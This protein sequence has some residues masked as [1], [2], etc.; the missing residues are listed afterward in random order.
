[1]V[2][3]TPSNTNTERRE[4]LAKLIELRKQVHNQIQ[5][6]E[7]EVKRREALRRKPGR[8]QALKRPKS[9]PPK[10]RIPAQW[11]NKLEPF[12]FFNEC[13][14]MT[15]STFSQNFPHQF[16]SQ[17][18]NVL[19]N[20]AFV[21]L[22]A[23][24]ERGDG[25]GDS[26]G[27]FSQSQRSSCPLSQ[28]SS[29]NGIDSR[30]PQISYPSQ[31]SQ[32]SDYHISQDFS[33]QGQGL[34]QNH[35]GLETGH[36]R[37]ANFASQV[38]SFQMQLLFPGAVS[39][40]GYSQSPCYKEDGD[41]RFSQLL[42]KANIALRLRT[43]ISWEEV[44]FHPDR[45]IFLKEDENRLPFIQGVYREK[46]YSRGPLKPTIERLKRVLTLLDVLIPALEKTPPDE[47]QKREL[48]YEMKGEEGFRFQKQVDS[49]LDD[50]C[51]HLGIS[52]T[53]L[54]VFAVA[55]GEVYGDITFTLR[56]GQSLVNCQ[57]YVSNL[58]EEKS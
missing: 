10:I 9:S 15:I 48:F 57:S 4:N 13:Q 50:I 35:A 22:Q 12:E 58:A 26:Q 45:G 42:T 6:D 14:G 56:N 47:H 16:D 7:E 43:S 25:R 3:T 41:S 37:Q 31:S 46:P 5:I 11:I 1:M 28:N 21:D 24:P 39:S 53:K 34:T 51:R 19:N 54:G 27:Y 30:L 20:Q 33:S 55:K 44:D 23:I 36:H 32:T 40:Q 49:I 29:S 17:Y 2:P 18:G 8:A 38:G 52:R